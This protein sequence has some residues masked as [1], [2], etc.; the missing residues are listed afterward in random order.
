MAQRLVAL[1]A[2]QSGS[3]G[4]NC[5]ATLATL[6]PNN[7]MGVGVDGQ[8][9]VYISDS[10]NSRIR[11]VSVNQTFPA[12]NSGS[13][14]TSDLGSCTLRLGTRLRRLRRSTITGSPD[15]VVNT[16]ANCTTNSTSDNTTDCTITVSFAPT[17]PG[18]DFATLTVKSA[19]GATSKFALSGIG[20][21]AAVALDP[22]MASSIGTGYN[23]PVG[24]AIDAAG[25]TYV[26]DT[27]NNV[28]IRYNNSGNGM[29]IA[30]TRVP[31][32]IAEMAVR[33]RRPLFPH[34]RR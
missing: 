30:G 25:N 17:R 26:A 7:A 21:A 19:L 23:S 13:S 14:I 20:A 4:D 18:L 8:G 2:G 5:Q 32:E 12:V 28:V 10:V 29:I 34:R 33:R 3:I 1:D 16:P 24:I 22:G 15:F 9:N 11:K 31:P 6:N 27:G